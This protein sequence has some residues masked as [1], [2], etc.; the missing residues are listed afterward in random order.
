MRAA[1]VLPLVAAASI[2]LVFLHAMYQAHAKI[3]P[4]DVYS[5]DVAIALT[6]G[7]A[8]LAGF[9]FGWE[10]L[11]RGRP[12]WVVAGALLAF[13]VISCFWRPLELPTKHLVTAAKTIEYA[14]LAPAVVLLFRRRVDVDR[15]LA[16]F[17][18]WA[19]AAA[20]WGV[21]MFF[22]IVDDPEG[23]RPGQREVSFLGHQDLGAFTGA[24]LAIGFAAIVL[25]VRPRLAL[26]A[27]IA[28]SLG[29]ILDAS[30][31]AY[32]GTVLAAVAAGWI[33]RRV[34]TLTLRRALA[35]AGILVVVGSGVYVLRGS[36]VSNYLSF[37]GITPATTSVAG[38]V[39][40]GSQRT[41]LLWIGWRMWRD[42]PVLGLGFERSNF[43]FKPYLAAARRR[44][45]NLPAEAFPSDQHR[46][47]VQN[48]WMELLADTGI[49]GFALGVATFVTGLV[50]ALRRA[51]QRSFFALVA[52]GFILVAAG[53]WN[54]L[55]L[56]AG[57]PLDAVMWLGFG[58][59]VVA[60][61]VA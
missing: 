8:I 13:F 19:A 59:S 31:F 35:I 4:L 52:A 14:L 46:W 55:G 25:A 29:V 27:V 40:T 41:M 9:K 38:Q 22:A 60:L 37:L 49:V 32:L 15:F 7:A 47:G 23:P 36:D 54:A 43:D 1:D 33:G 58:L 45:P 56:V 2:P 3:G 21:L 17:V 28:G 48:L 42:H 16:V 51:G 61:E 6:V 50:L 5:S 57:I 44:F 18:A 39:E 53:T 11:A 24:A 12:L 30:V 26:V 34:G 20:A 10:P